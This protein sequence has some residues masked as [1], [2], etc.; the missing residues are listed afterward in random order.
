MVDE[1]GQRAAMETGST[2]GD[3]DRTVDDR[4][5]T[6]C[7]NAERQSEHLSPLL[8]GNPHSLSAA[9]LAKCNFAA[10]K[11]KGQLLRLLLG[12]SLVGIALS[13]W[14]L[15]PVELLIRK[16]LAFHEGSYLYE[17]WRN[18]PVPIKHNVFVFNV[19]NADGFLHRGEKLRV[20][21]VGPYVYSE[22]LDNVVLNFNDNGTI[23]YIPNRTETFSEELSER[24][25]KEDIVIIPNLALIALIS[26]VHKYPFYLRWLAIKML[27]P[28]NLQPFISITVNE[29]MLGY[30]DP[31]VTLGNTFLS[32]SLPI[33]KIGIFYLIQRMNDTITMFTNPDD[34]S[35]TDPKL[36][37]I[38]VMNG[39]PG[40][41]N[42]GYG[43]KY[44]ETANGTIVPEL[45]KC[46][47]AR[48]TYEGVI[49][50]RYLPEN[51]TMWV[52]RKYFC[53][54]I[55]AVFGKNVTAYGL[56]LRQYK[57]K[58]DAYDTP[59]KNPDNSCYCDG[60]NRDC[61]PAGVAEVSPCYFNV[62]AAISNP[63]FLNG[64]ESLLQA[65]D[66]LSPD[67]EKHE[68]YFSV[69]TDLGLPIEGNCKIQINLIARTSGMKSISA[70]HGMF[71]PIIW[72]E[73]VIG[74]YP[75]GLM[76]LIRVALNEGP[77]ILKVL[78]VLFL[79]AGLILV[80][81]IISQ[82]FYPLTHMKSKFNAVR[83]RK[84]SET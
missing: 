62:P 58:D 84:I 31:L 19:T 2:T 42:W 79:I 11:Y 41:E 1:E 69:S 37:S 20:E 38:D 39:S 3:G 82:Q 74:P 26:I 12:V 63:H 77:M 18:P 28:L 61:L 57:L 25:A 54:P 78:A 45:L 21:E 46:N 36:Y 72:F 52:Y 81:M 83:F 4:E 40:L 6:P 53:R 48:G 33:T 13:I 15:D 47:S 27:A 80:L 34:L 50:P 73:T 56:K 60:Q 29:L 70:F 59:D 65:I 24:N 5:C 49:L 35:R 55:P 51:E 44:V 76:L 43:E 23:T 30:E 32:K 66:G 14:F 71:L 67:Q 7:L 68:S 17:H 8:V 16:L 9:T 75:D 64:D 22:H 10:T